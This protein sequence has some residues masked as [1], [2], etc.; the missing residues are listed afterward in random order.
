MFRNTCFRKQNKSNDEHSIQNVPVFKPQ[1]MTP[2]FGAE[3]LLSSDSHSIP[4]ISI[5]F[6][7]AES[8]GCGVTNECSSCSSALGLRVRSL[9][10]GARRACSL[11]AVPGEG[12]AVQLEAKEV[13]AVVREGRRV[14]E[15]W[16]WRA[17]K[18]RS[19]GQIEREREGE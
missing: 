19:E 7:V 18:R 14:N 2:H 9:P 4:P 10:R 1:H 13:A 5:I 17:R 15:E 6:I 11:S 16:S 12:A 3:K 8:L